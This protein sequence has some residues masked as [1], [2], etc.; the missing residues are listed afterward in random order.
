MREKETLHEKQRGTQTKQKNIN[1]LKLKDYEKE[2]LDFSSSSRSARS[3]Q[4]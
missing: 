3:M 4:Q 2:L 1:F